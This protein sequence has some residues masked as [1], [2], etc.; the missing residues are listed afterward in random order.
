MIANSGLGHRHL[1]LDYIPSIAYFFKFIIKNFSLRIKATGYISTAVNTNSRM[2][3]MLDI[4]NKL[5]TA[6]DKCSRVSTAIETYNR[7]S[8]AIE[9]TTGCRLQ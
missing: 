9:P 4:C 8:T 3:A 7:V 5:M 1:F 6:M 2:H